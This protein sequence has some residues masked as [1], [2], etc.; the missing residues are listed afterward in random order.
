MEE[1]G[2]VDADVPIAH[3]FWLKNGR[4]M[5]SLRD[6]YENL[7]LM[8][9]EVFSHHVTAEKND[10]A[11]WVRDVL[12]DAHLARD[13][14]TVRSRGEAIELLRRRLGPAA[15]GYASLFAPDGVPLDAL[16][17]PMPSVILPRAEIRPDFGFL[18]G[19]GGLPPAQHD[20]PGQRQAEP[21]ARPL[22]ARR[23]AGGTLSYVTDELESVRRSYERR[24]LHAQNEVDRFKRKVMDHEK[25]LYTYE[26]SLVE[27]DKALAKKEEE[28]LR[29]MKRIDQFKRYEDE[30]PQ[31][32]G[33]YAQVKV[34]Y[35][36][37]R[38]RFSELQSGYLQAKS[39]KDKEEEVADKELALKKVE[40]QLRL[41]EKRLRREEKDLEKKTYD[42]FI[43]DKD[44]DREIEQFLA[45]KTEASGRHTFLASRKPDGDDRLAHEIAD[46][47]GK[48]RNLILLRKFEPAT[49]LFHR[50]REIYAK[51]ELDESAKRSLYYDILELKTDLDLALLR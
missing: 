32:E 39:L 41:M 20:P 47:I 13:L 40:T 45:A 19:V 28:V 42:E 1:A 34:D 7:F 2:A 35:D 27:K 31:L 26:L 49:A 36:T 48:T 6:F 3:F 17:D 12:G 37:L 11:N 24:F 38:K 10:F 30:L 16:G 15:R 25:R 4:P 14:Y 18:T 43:T 46:L 22:P 23:I 5:K 9:D 44:L 21:R 51:A 8:D 33:A 29:R 50:L